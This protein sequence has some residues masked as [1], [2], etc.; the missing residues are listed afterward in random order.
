M[1]LVVSWSLV[2]AAHLAG[3][4]PLRRQSPSCACLNWREAYL[5]DRVR[6]GQGL[7]RYADNFGPVVNL[8]V[9]DNDPSILLMQQ[10]GRLTEVCSQ[11][12]MR[13]NHSYAMNERYS[14]FTLG[15]TRTWCY[16]SQSACQVVD[17][18]VPGT[19][20][21]VKLFKQGEVSAFRELSMD[22]ILD[23][24]SKD[25]ISIGMLLQA[26][27]YSELGH[28]KYDLDNVT[29][30]LLTP[31]QQ[32]KLPILLSPRYEKRPRLFV[33]G[34]RIVTFYPGWPRGSKPAD[35]HFTPPEPPVCPD[36]SCEEFDEYNEICIRC[37]GD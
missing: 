17:A 13:M 1:F 10:Q 22:K 30:D 37:E 8:S 31:F 12:F 27:C 18:A 20:V 14:P 36:E 35:R 24:A 15:D 21:A 3:G 33:Y 34:D 6:C 9:S 5:K 7:E 26:G 4:V 2:L 19:D 23:I 11:L 32:K 25:V 28:P 29:Q 16:V